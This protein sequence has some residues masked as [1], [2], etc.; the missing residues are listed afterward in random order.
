M[1]E[2]ETWRLEAGV[3]PSDVSP[4]PVLAVAA[5]ILLTLALSAGAIWLLLGWWRMPTG[6]G[7]DAPE[8]PRTALPRLQAA[9]QDEKAAYF[10]EK[11]RLLHDY[12]WVDRQAGTARI[13][14]EVAMDLL[15]ARGAAR[16]RPGGGGGRP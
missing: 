4:R 8:G 7:P 1:P 10:A 13:P 11:D 5:A 12:G 14:I 3:E 16:P 6:A 15:A 9:P 2:R